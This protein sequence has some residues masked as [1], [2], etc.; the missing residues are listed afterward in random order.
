M[1]KGIAMVAKKAGLPDDEFHRYWREIHGPLAL[2]MG[3]LRR[4]VQSHRSHYPLP[5]FDQVPYDGV[6]EIWFDTLDEIQNLPKNPDYINNAQADEPN[7]IDVHKLAFLATR[8]HVVIEG[9]PIS[10]DTAWIK[11]IF[12]LRRRTDMTVAQF[13]DYWLHSHAPQIPRD[14]GVLRY[15]QCHQIP[16]TYAQSTPAYDGVAELWFADHASFLNYWT[17]PH[18]QKIF[19]DDAPRFLDGATCT[20][21]LAQEYR[22]RWP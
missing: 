9:P 13:Q 2:R 18:I 15:V 8:E 11:A 14:A 10:Q 22:V 21:F 3:N 5:G 7:F 16:E 6:A 19:G 1:I 20:A 4:Y 12:L 17:S